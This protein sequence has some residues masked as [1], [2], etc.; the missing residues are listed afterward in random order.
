VLTE[1]EAVLAAAVQAGAARILDVRRSGTVGGAFKNA[2]EL[3]TEADRQSDTAILSVL[4]AHLPAID[5]TLSVHLEESGVTGTPGARRIG[6]DPL[7][8]TSHFASGGNL[9]SVQA[10]YLDDGAPLVGVVFQPE[11]FL[12]LAETD[13]PVGRFVSAIRGQG[14][15]TRRTEFVDG[16]F[17][18]SASRRV[19]AEGWT[20]GARPLVA[21]VP[22]S[23]KMRPDERDRA[24]RVYDSGILGATTGTGGAGGNVMMIVFGGQDV[25]ANF[26]AGEDLDLAPP[27]VIAE[28]AGLTVWGPDRRPPIWH[29]RKQPFVVARDAAMAERLLDVAGL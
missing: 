13:R 27:Q 29:V 9:Y 6:A 22:Y 14:A 5:P 24:R 2:T 20:A 23:G 17:R 16:A 12:P 10:H 1:I 19:T 21:C 7:D 15:F 18:M 8:G 28:E 3:V 25:Y 11:V 4:T 26:G